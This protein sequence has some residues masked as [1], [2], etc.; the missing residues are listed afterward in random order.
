[1]HAKNPKHEIRNKKQISNS[2]FQ[3][4]NRLGFMVS[5]LAFVS[6]FDIRIS[7]L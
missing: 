2:K 1:M 7:N 4:Q 3:I 5:D 6:N